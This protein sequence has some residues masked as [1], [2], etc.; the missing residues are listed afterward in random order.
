MK[1]TALEMQKVRFAYQP[2]H[3]ALNDIS[4]V[5]AAGERVALVGPNGAGKTTLFLCLAGVL[6]PQTGQM[7]VCGLDPLLPADRKQLPRHL[8][9]IFQDSDDQIFSTTVQ[10]D[11]AFGPLNLGLPM[12]EVMQRT[13]QAL[14]QVGLSGFEERVPH[15]L[16]GGEKRRVALAGVLAMNPDVLLL[17]EPTA[18]L[19]PKGR[20]TLIELLCKQPHTMLIASHDLEFVLEIGQRVILLDQGRIVADGL[21]RELLSQSEL[22]EAHGLEV[23]YSLRCPCT[24]GK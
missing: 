20:R 12:P 1:S 13:A 21:P 16:S 7:R 22:L 9:I 10:D 24:K 4:C 17:D 18:F 23:P 19:D 11:V 8:G 5:I 15:H 6:V 3:F 2:D 14:A